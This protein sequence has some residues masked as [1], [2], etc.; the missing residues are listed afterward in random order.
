VFKNWASSSGVLGLESGFHFTGIN[1]VMPDRT[2]LGLL[3]RC[4]SVG[5]ISG[6]YCIL[7]QAKM[8]VLRP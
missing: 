3:S 6:D 4:A 8:V 1:G 2:I 5:L 7:K